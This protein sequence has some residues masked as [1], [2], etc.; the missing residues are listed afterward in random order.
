MKWLIEQNRRIQI[1]NVTTL[2]VWG[3][4]TLQGHFSTTKW[5]MGQWVGIGSWPRFLHLWNHI[6]RA[7]AMPQKGPIQ[8]T[9]WCFLNSILQLLI[10]QDSDLQQSFRLKK[11]CN[12]SK[13]S[14][15]AENFE[16]SLTEH[17]LIMDR[18]ST[19]R[20]TDSTN[21]YPWVSLRPTKEHILSRTRPPCSYIADSQLG[22]HVGPE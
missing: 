5:Y 10:P 15:I 7:L 3:A 12:I 6:N 9:E 19:G 18:N 8:K 4:Q 20:P 14:L 1:S 21:L 11:S 13:I 22:L 16:N 2:L 17:I